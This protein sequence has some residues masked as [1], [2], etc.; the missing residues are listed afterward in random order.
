LKARLEEI[1]VN[2]R[3]YKGYGK[4]RI[5]MPETGAVID[6]R[7][8]TSS[9]ALGSGY[10]L[11]VIDEAQEYTKAQQTALNY[12]VSSSKNPQTIMCGTPPTAVSSGD[13]FRD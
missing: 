1:G 12:V 4:E 9:G 3:S 11:L 6:F 13:V 7:T 5:E 8:R 10:D 2:F